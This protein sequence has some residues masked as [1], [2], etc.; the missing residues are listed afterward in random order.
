MDK[1]KQEQQLRG[2][3]TRAKAFNNELAILQKKHAV[4]IYAANCVLKNGEVAPLVRL[5]D[6]FKPA[7]N[8]KIE[9]AKD[10]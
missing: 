2:L 4:K 8:F 6:D 7:D 9:F 10:K 1:I 3:E 5:A